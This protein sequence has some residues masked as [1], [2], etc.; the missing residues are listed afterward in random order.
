M[1]EER[2]SVKYDF[3]G[4][5][6]KV[7]NGNGKRELVKNYEDLPE[8]AQK[9]LKEGK[10]RGEWVPYRWINKISTTAILSEIPSA[11]FLADYIAQHI[12]SAVAAIAI[13]FIAD[14]AAGYGLLKRHEK[15]MEVPNE[16]LPET[17]EEPDPEAKGE[18]AYLAIR[19]HEEQP[20][21]RE[22]LVRP[23]PPATTFEIVTLGSGGL[24]LKYS[25]Q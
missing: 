1:S 3:W 4:R 14:A 18:T 25:N 2:K 23:P 20:E 15:Y 8:W 6:W 10:A 5:G 16:P 19:P 11:I 9:A 17:K 7:V 12:P 22:E 21:W 13:P 24:Y